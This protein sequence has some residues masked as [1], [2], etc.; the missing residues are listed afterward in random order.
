RRLGRVADCRD[1][2]SRPA[3][4]IPLGPEEGDDGPGGSADAH[5]DAGGEEAG[6]QGTT[7]DGVIRARLH[8][9]REAVLPDGLTLFPSFLARVEGGALLARLTAELDWEQQEFTI[10]G[11]TTPMPRLIAMYGPCGYR[12]SGVVHPPRSL[13]P[14]LDAVRRRVELTTGR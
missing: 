8:A 13:P 10:Y 3:P 6:G 9:G 11:R 2:R 5:G 4:G 12:Y 7:R 1:G 14:V